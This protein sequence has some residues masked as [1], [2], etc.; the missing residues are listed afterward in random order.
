MNNFAKT[1]NQSGNVFLFVLLGVALF[2]ALAFVVS[3]GMRSESATGLSRNQAELSAVDII[4]YAQNLERG[5]NRLR[6]HSVSENDIDFTNG[7]VTGYEHSPVLP[8]T[9]QVFSK[10]G[11]GI[12]WKN[13]ETNVNDG[14]PWIF[15]GK[16][17]IVNIGTGGTGCEG[18][19]VNDEELVAVLPN[20]KANV[21]EELN[22]RLGISPMPSGG[23]I[24]T[25]KFTGT[26]SD[27][28]SPGTDGLP[29][30]CFTA[31]G[32]FYFYYVLLPR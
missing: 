10:T 13:P 25:T 19:S 26:Y 6:D 22:K 9:D 12:S 5:V 2:A 17:C 11:G 28:A 4:D 29:A 18:N 15:T 1:S 14:S 20:L 31:G 27:D 16:M 32:N 7:V 3:R 8:D 23:H 30:A 24:S 21:C